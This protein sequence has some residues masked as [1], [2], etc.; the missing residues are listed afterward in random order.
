MGSRIRSAQQSDKFGCGV[1]RAGQEPSFPDSDYDQQTGDIMRDLYA[2]GSV[3]S[4]AKHGST[5]KD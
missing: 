5:G 2:R 3:D 4:P 1:F